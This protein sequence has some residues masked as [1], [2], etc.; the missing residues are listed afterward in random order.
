VLEVMRLAPGEEGEAIALRLMGLFEAPEEPRRQ[1]VAK[2][3]RELCSALALVPVHVEPWAPVNRRACPHNSD[4]TVVVC[5]R[6]AD[7]LGGDR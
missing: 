2:A 7:G 4:R 5:E 3:V 6:R 1:P